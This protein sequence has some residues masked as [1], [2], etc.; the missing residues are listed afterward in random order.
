VADCYT[1]AADGTLHATGQGAADCAGY[2][3]TSGAEY[4]QLQ[5]LQEIFTWPAPETLT[6]WFMGAFVLVLTLNACGYIVGAVVKMVST[7]R[8]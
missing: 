1:I 2:V 4:A 3:M 6:N 7:E 5:F 8:A